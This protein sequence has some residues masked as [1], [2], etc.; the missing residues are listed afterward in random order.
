MKEQ[1]RSDLRL[2]RAN[3]EK[4]EIV[5]DIIKEYVSQGYRLTLRQLYYQLVSR[6]IVPN[7]QSEYSKLSGL[8]VKGRMGGEVDW[9][10]IEDRIRVPFLPYWCEG[11]H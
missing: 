5:N 1:F 8:L 11:C 6:D 10:A 9:S 3:V 2:S 7:I 4:L